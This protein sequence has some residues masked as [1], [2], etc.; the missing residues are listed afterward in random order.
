[1]PFYTPA[2]AVS[3]PAAD[4]HSTA[5]PS[6]LGIV[7]D[8]ILHRP[9][10]TP[11]LLLHSSPSQYAAPQPQNVSNLVA[12]RNLATADILSSP[13]LPIQAIQSNSKTTTTDVELR[14]AIR[15]PRMKVRGTS[16][17]TISRRA[18]RTSTSS[19]YSPYLRPSPSSASSF[20]SSPASS[21]PSLSPSS[22]SSPNAR[23]ASSSESP[24]RLTCPLPDC[25]TPTRTYGRRADLER[26]LLTAGAHAH[27]H[28]SLPPSDAWACCGLP[29]AVAR[30]RAD[31][32][33]AVLAQR[34]RVYHGVAMVGGCGRT[35]SRKDALARH[36]E[37]RAGRC[38]GECAGEWLVGNRDR[39]VCKRRVEAIVERC[40]TVGVGRTQM[41]MEMEMELSSA[42]DSVSGKEKLPKATLRMEV[43]GRGTRR[44]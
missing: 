9:S 38:W 18:P 14:E 13:V 33:A 41:E 7:S 15:M 2:T 27:A 1:M 28:P 22:A 39:E 40:V 34:P 21:S 25:P 11:G 29:L 37:R 12:L 4:P 42:A 43:E 8:P 36:L 6:L 16:S 5:N 31:V 3:H 32:P 10:A 23:Q 19:R 35:N 26:H 24:L 44:Q 17:R 30:L 20:T